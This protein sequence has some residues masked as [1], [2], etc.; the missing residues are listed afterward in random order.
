MSAW[1]QKQ[2]ARSGRAAV[3]DAPPEVVMHD[4]ISMYQEAPAGE[5]CI[6]EFEHFAIDRLRGKAAYLC[7]VRCLKPLPGQGHISR[8]VPA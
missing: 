3:E 7:P 6:E 5:V 4:R 8:W 2:Q 1:M